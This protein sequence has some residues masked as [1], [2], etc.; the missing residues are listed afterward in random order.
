MSSVATAHQASAASAFNPHATSVSALNRHVSLPSSAALLERYGPTCAVLGSG[1]CSDTFVVTRPWDKKCFAIK[2]FKPRP[3]GQSEAEYIKKLT[4]EFCIGTMLHHPNVVETVDLIIDPE[5]HAFEVMELC[6][7]GDLFDAIASTEM[8]PAEADC[9][10]AQLLRGVAYMHKVGVCHRDLK[11]E[12]LLFDSTNHLKIIDFGSAEIILPT[13]TASDS[14]GICGTGPYMAPEEFL[15]VPYDGRKVDIWACGVIYLVMMYC[16]FPW[17]KAILTDPN[18]SSYVHHS[19]G[20]PWTRFFDNL[21]DGPRSLIPRMLHPDPE[22]RPLVT[23]VLE[24]EW[25]KGIFC[26]C[27]AAPKADDGSP[28]VTTGNMEPNPRAASSSASHPSASSS[29]S[30]VCH[31]HGKIKS[32]LRSSMQRALNDT[33]R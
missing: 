27:D 21:P 9:C 13:P 14:R 29:Q 3:K 33:E 15:G 23:E 11:P 22:K 30:T 25:F 7:N 18:Y 1:S 19:S 32:L 17:E 26:C 16:R 20:H 12:N 10:F 6:E 24:D 5:Q 28:D 8:T 31:R 2:E 4:S